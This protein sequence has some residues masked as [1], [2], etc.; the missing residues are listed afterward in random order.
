MPSIEQQHIQAAAC[1]MSLAEER[2]LQP[3][4]S[5]TWFEYLTVWDASD[6]FVLLHYIIFL[7]VA[8]GALSLAKQELTR[9]QESYTRDSERIR[10]D[11]EKHAWQHVGSERAGDLLVEEG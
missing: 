2:L 11:D 6:F 3:L 7:C 5:R 8:S 1:R 10:S 9:A 4:S